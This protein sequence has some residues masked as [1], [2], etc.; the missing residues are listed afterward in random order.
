MKLLGVTGGVGMG[1][2]T[3]AE[4][5][6]QAGVAVVD[7]DKIAREVVEP[8][9]PALEEIRREFGAH[10]IG[11][12][13]RLLRSEL[14]RLVFSDAAARSKLEAILHPRIRAAWQ[15]E[16]EV[17][18][19]EGRE[20]GAVIIPLLYETDAASFFSSV[21]CVVCSSETQRRRLSDRGWTQQEIDRRNAA[22]WP[23]ERKMN[24]ADFVVW[25][26][27]RLEVHA[28]QLRRVLQMI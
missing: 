19:K 4:F 16:V 6:R 24:L 13:G 27:G 11:Q 28:A 17:W 21:L 5:L 25:T 1:K 2:S 18:K 10:F 14:A 23:V 12:N 8:G 26:E 7:T 9:K 3:A 22:Q 15:Q 20:V